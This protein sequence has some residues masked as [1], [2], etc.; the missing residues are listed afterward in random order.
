MTGSVVVGVD[1]TG[2]SVPAVHWG[3]TEAAARGLPLHLLHSWASQPLSVRDAHRDADR[4]RCGAEV[5]DAAAAAARAA[6]PGISVTTEL[7]P[8]EAVAALTKRSGT[9]SMLV[10][11]SRGH[12]AI[13]GFLLGS[14]SLHVLR[15]AE[16]PV[17][18]VRGEQKAEYA[19]PEI[20]IGVRDS[21]AAV[22]PVLDFGFTAAG[23]HHTS[24]RAVRVRQPDERSRPVPGSAGRT[25][26]EAGPVCGDEQ[27]LT[28]TLL[29]WRAKFPEVDVIE[30]MASGR[31]APVLLAACSQAGL[32]VIGRGVRRS[33]LAPGPVVLAVLHHAPCPVA[34]V[35][36][37]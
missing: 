27:A 23:V 21:G 16:C 37:V 1:G 7:V 9:A 17:V 15:S 3:A 18:T 2:N 4:K 20:V 12:S 34:V 36:E 8:E 6:Y 30:H 11:G 33:A 25:P 31:V 13:D 19:E 26:G 5:L 32:L 14:V 29:P 28:D 24:L 10:L 35:P 22:E